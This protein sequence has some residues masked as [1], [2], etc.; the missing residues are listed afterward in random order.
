M[1]G[2][3]TRFFTSWSG[4]KDSCLALHRALTAGAKPA[5][6]LTII[7]EDGIRSRSHGL[8]RDVLEAQASAMG[9]PLLIRCASWAEYESVFVDALREIRKQGVETGV[10]GDIDF[11]PHLEWEKKVCA[12]TDMTAYLPLWGCSREQLLR[13]FLSLGYK[14]VIV[15]VDEKKLD[16]KFLGRMIDREIINEFQKMGIDPCGENGEYHTLVVDGPVFS[17][18]LQFETGARAEHSGYCSIDIRVRPLAGK[19][20]KPCAK[21]NT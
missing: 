12:T 1:P 6:L 11:P 15:T 3:N 14:A 5:Y 21:T 10:F 19:T 16:R 18:P 2:K 13:E 17:S 8:R 7:S 4:G 9:I 20:Q